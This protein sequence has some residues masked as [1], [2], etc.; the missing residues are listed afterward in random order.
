LLL[1][2]ASRAQATIM[3]K[4]ASGRIACIIERATSEREAHIYACRCSS[5]IDAAAADASDRLYITHAQ[6]LHSSD[7]RP[8]V[9]AQESCGDGCI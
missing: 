6:H 8:V 7:V 2:D 3:Y 9:H 1:L 5:K 4:Q